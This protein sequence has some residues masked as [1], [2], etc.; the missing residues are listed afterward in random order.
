[1]GTLR[2]RLVASFVVLVGVSL[3]AVGTYVYFR[4]ESGLMREV[5]S[6][7]SA[8]AAQARTL[9][10]ERSGELAFPRVGGVVN[11]LA[12]NA[13]FAYQVLS[14][15][16]LQWES[17]GQSLAGFASPGQAGYSTVDL[18]GDPWR[19]IALPAGSAPGPQGWIRV[20]RSLQPTRQLLSTLRTQLYLVL[21]VVLVLAAL[22]GY[23]LA[24]RALRPLVVISRMADVIGPRDL[25]RRIRYA[26]PADEVGRLAA[27]FDRMLDRVE[28]AFHR[29]R[30]FTADA[31][32]ELRTPLTTLKGSIGVVLARPRTNTEYE[33]ALQDLD[34]QV[35]GLIRLCSDL[36]AL[37]RAGGVRVAEAE[38]IDLSELL[39]VVVQQLCPV[40]ETKAVALKTTLQPGVTVRGSAD[41]LIRLFLNLLTNG[42]KFSPPSGVVEISLATQ[43]A[44]GGSAVV[45]VSDAGPGISPEHLP[46]LFEPFYQAHAQSRGEPGTGLG[47][48]IS[49]E[50][51]LAHGGTLEVTSG[52]G[53]GSEFTVRLPL[54]G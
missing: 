4:T 37:A 35:D 8:A 22:A 33:E 19:M 3:L 12:P 54:E 17:L 36:L 30:R 5:D 27:A 46:H 41:D 2:Q 40:A 53:K 26:G 45:R 32:H 25:D 42:I 14:D 51:V 28:R 21:P 52:P 39:E 50:I 38:D 34:G 48:A 44:H 23:V 49:Q 1:V 18:F 20:A 43:G 16:G 24:G 31:S 11:G 29:E 15:S 10:E 9:L 6:S 7:L 47:L 13:G